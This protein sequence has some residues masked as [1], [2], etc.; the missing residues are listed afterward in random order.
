MR[1]C[2]VIAM[3]EG[4]DILFFMFHSLTS[5]TCQL[6][7]PQTTTC[8]ALTPAAFHEGNQTHHRYDQ[9][10]KITIHDHPFEFHSSHQ[11]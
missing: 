8:D 9:N 7:G 6:L 1:I 11:L 3:K 4:K 2:N 5:E 10:K